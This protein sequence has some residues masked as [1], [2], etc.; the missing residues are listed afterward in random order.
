VLIVLPI[1]VLLLIFR[2]SRDYGGLGIYFASFPVGLSLWV[3]C[4]VYAL[5]VSI[6][7]TVAGVFL[8]GLGIVPIA[9]IMTLIRKDWSS[10]GG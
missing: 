2:P 5:G 9:A 10:F 6:F 7:W 3:T 8:G 1:S 4:F